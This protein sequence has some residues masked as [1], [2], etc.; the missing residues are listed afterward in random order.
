M[1]ADQPVL[2]ADNRGYRYGDGLFETLKIENGRLRLFSF[3][4]DRLWSG[5]QLLKL[6]IPKLFTPEKLQAEIIQLC[7]EKSLY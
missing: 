6:E 4:I 7:G 3:H 2:M 5:M 1:T